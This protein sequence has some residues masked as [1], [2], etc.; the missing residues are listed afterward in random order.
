ML[1]RGVFWAICVIVSL[2]CLSVSASG[3]QIYFDINGDQLPDTESIIDIEGTLLVGVYLSDFGE[4]TGSFQFDIAYDDA[5]LTL[6]DYDTYVGQPDQDPG[7]TGPIQTLAELGPWATSQWS[8]PV[9]QET[10]EPDGGSGGRLE[11]YTAGSF[12]ETATGDGV[13][14]WL[15]FD[16]TAI[17]ETTLAL[18][19]PGDTWFIEN[20]TEQPTPINLNVCVI[21]EP[22]LLVALTFALGFLVREAARRK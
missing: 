9:T 1:P 14:A 18:Q 4:E 15:V 10:N 17:G 2:L 3:A 22:S 12:T 13:L 19:M 6:I 5:V 7:L 16:A 8:E 11:F 21:P 20:V